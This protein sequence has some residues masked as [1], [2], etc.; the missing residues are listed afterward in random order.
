VEGCAAIRRRPRRCKLLAAHALS[1]LAGS[2]I[3]SWP[4]RSPRP[5]ELG[6]QPQHLVL[7]PGL[8]PGCPDPTAIDSPFVRSPQPPGL[9]SR[10]RALG[11]SIP[12]LGTKHPT[13]APPRVVLGTQSS[14]RKA[15]VQFRALSAW[16]NVPS[17]WRFALSTGHATPVAQHYVLGARWWIPRTQH[18]APANGG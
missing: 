11:T 10:H 16:S 1:R 13:L 3:V 9:R 5:A 4:R 18:V 17:A 12:L 2:M 6:A 14:L 8:N 15:S 7:V